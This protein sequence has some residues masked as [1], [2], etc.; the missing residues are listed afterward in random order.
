[1]T[2]SRE[3]LA[4]VGQVL[5]ASGNLAVDDECRHTEDAGFPRLAA[6]A[7]DLRRPF[8]DTGYHLSKLAEQV[9]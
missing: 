6:D 1:L 4:D 3:H 8:G 2:G 5:A 9:G 7:L